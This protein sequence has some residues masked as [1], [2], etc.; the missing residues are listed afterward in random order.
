[1]PSAAYNTFLDKPFKTPVILVEVTPKELLQGW[2]ASAGTSNVYQ[3]VFENFEADS[4]IQGGLYK[5]LINV[6]QNDH[7]LSLVAALTTCDVTAGS[8]FFDE[9]PL[10]EDST[11]YV[12]TT[13]GADPDTYTAIMAEFRVHFSTHPK[14][15][16]S[17]F[18]EPRLTS[19]SLPDVHAEVEDLFFGPIK[20]VAEGEISINNADG[21]FDIISVN[22]A[23]KNARVEIYFGGDEL[24]HTPGGGGDYERIG[25]FLNENIAPG[26]EEATLFVRDAQKI[27][28]R[29]FPITPLF[30][31]DFPDI[32]D[33][34]RGIRI[35]LLFG[36]KTNITP[37]KIS[38]NQ[39]GM[40]LI[41]DSNYQSLYEISKVYND[42][43][44]I[45]SSYLVKSLTGCSFSVLSA[46]PNSV[47]TITCDAIGQPVRGKDWETSA[48]YLKYYAEIVCE[49]YTNYLGLSDSD[50]S[51]TDA[52]SADALEPAPQAAY[53]TEERT[54]RA[55][56]RGFE[57][58]VLGRTIRQA[59]GTIKPTIW[60]PGFD[61]DLATTIE[62]PDIVEFD[63][64]PKIET[65]FSR[66]L[67][68]GDQ[69]PT[70]GSYPIVV[71]R[72]DNAARY[73]HLDGRI[74]D[75]TVETFLKGNSDAEVLADRIRFVSKNPDIDV[76][77]VET[78]V[79][80]MNTDIGDRHLVSFDRAPSP[81]GSWTNKPVEVL[82][83]T[84]RFAPIPSVE[85]LVNDLKGVGPFIGVWVG[86]SAP[87]YTSATESQ[88]LQSGYWTDD[89]GFPDPT[90][91]QSINSSLWW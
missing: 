56:I 79:R 86:D 66:V 77:I 13:G 15:F 73:L 35:P 47:G 58:G 81:T 18:Y 63:P 85:L 53:I 16:N 10:G 74:E 75:R 36:N 57:V 42:G 64:D 2:S 91:Q 23:W 40:F 80:L 26:L 70:D 11:L 90:D 78:G 88:R 34:I 8:Y 25:V 52:T 69:D 29:R 1:M 60:F 61:V 55:Y 59:D 84:K 38:E 82:G 65:I 44:E 22:W 89:D 46:Y 5:D 54:A 19:E 72:T 33:S 39:N 49:I 32:D 50:I 14:I 4:I 24:T 27:T 6:V 17:I 45:N 3:M 21:L 43:T 28:F 12:H 76:R 87:V 41:A 67:V 62:N 9:K 37:I 7:D 68:Y 48:D 71:E 20:K 51:S 30:E 31:S 83:V